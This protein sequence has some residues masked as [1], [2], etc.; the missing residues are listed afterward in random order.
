M[1]RAFKSVL[2]VFCL[3]SWKWTWR[4]ENT[5]QNHK[6][7]ETC[8]APLSSFNF[9]QN[10]VRCLSLCTSWDS[11]LSPVSETE[12]KP[13]LSCCKMDSRSYWQSRTFLFAVLRVLCS[14]KEARQSVMSQIEQISV[15]WL[16]F[17]EVWSLILGLLQHTS[18]TLP[19]I[20]HIC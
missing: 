3:L 11:L 8:R 12:L 13:H 6:C 9:D 4:S 16:W 15:K 10:R 14:F 17:R 2:L 1:L 7:V 20:L 18:K 19:Q 5:S